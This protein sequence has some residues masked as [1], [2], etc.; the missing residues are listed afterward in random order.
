MLNYSTIIRDPFTEDLFIYNESLK[1]PAGEMCVMNWSALKQP[2]ADVPDNKLLETFRIKT[3]YTTH[4]KLTC[5]KH[6]TEGEICRFD[7]NTSNFSWILR[8]QG[9]KTHRWPAGEGFC[10]LKSE[11][12]RLYGWDLTAGVRHLFVTWA[13][14]ICFGCRWWTRWECFFWHF[15]KGSRVN[16]MRFLKGSRFL[17]CVNLENIGVQYHF[18]RQPDGC[19]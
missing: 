13:F 17:K 11:R 19:F 2:T 15:L 8:W 12:F 14:E 6:L 10:W 3:T 16:T 9:K 1:I 7:D 18:F 5:I 4:N